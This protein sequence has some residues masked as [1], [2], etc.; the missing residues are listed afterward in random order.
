MSWGVLATRTSLRRERAAVKLIM[1]AGDI[2]PI[3]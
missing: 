3:L 2:A 1:A